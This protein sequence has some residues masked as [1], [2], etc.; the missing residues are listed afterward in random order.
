MADSLRWT[1]Y[2]INELFYLKK[3]RGHSKQRALKTKVKGQ[4]ELDFGD[5]LN[6][7]D[8]FLES[9]YKDTQLIHVGVLAIS[10]SWL[11]D[12]STSRKRRFFF[13]CNRPMLCRNSLPH[14]CSYF[15]TSKHLDG[16]FKTYTSLIIASY[17]EFV[18]FTWSR[19]ALARLSFRRSCGT[20]DAIGS[21]IAVVTARA[22][23]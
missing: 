12:N 13:I 6:E 18:N 14:I 19:R 23:T 22:T 10:R 21:T 5:L 1:R 16:I 20:F 8:N 17:N 7:T 15:H 4:K 11:S 2:F 3:K 9:K